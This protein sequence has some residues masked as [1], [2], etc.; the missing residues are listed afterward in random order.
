M[1]VSDVRGPQRT[2]RQRA[3]DAIGNTRE[4]GGFFYAHFVGVRGGATAAGRSELA[5]LPAPG[6]PRPS[7]MA[8]GTLADLALGSALRSALGTGLLMPTVDLTLTLVREPRGEVVA[9]GFALPT[10]TGSAT[11]TAS[12]DLSDSDGRVGLASGTFALRP[13]AA[14]SVRSMPWDTALSPTGP[15]DQPG[16]PSLAPGDLSPEE[17]ACL[18]AVLYDG[19]RAS[20]GVDAVDDALLG[21]SAFPHETEETLVEARV[22]PALANR[23]G[24]LHGGAL[25]ALVARTAQA[26]LGAQP[27]D[28]HTVTLQFLRPVTGPELSGSASVR[29]RGRSSGVVAVD[30]AGL[31]AGQGDLLATALV[32]LKVGR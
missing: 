25:I 11:A 26:A 5:V 4:S 22:G 20:G 30:V 7:T 3:I 24:Y 28:L 14:R 6:Q 19:G 12:C 31:R 1:G 27:T 29:R 10:A 32:A 21:F 8:V 15:I 13:A 17:R 18:E 23:A 9:Q 16:P 2:P